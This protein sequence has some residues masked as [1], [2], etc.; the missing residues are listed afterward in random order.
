M[1]NGGGEHGIS[2]WSRV[3][4]RLD[5]AI[6]NR[7]AGRGHP[8]L[9]PWSIDDM[10][11]SFEQIATTL[12]WEPLGL[13]RCLDRTDRFRDPVAREWAL[14]QNCVDYA[15][16]LLDQWSWLVCHASS[17]VEAGAIDQTAGMAAHDAIAEAMATG[18]SWAAPSSGG[19]DELMGEQVRELASLAEAKV[20]G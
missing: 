20:R 11:H 12:G 7:R 1:F 14:T 13:N 8:P 15:A 18:A 6:N 3:K 16:S 5:A 9:D 2:G 10:R 4:R 19:V 17:A